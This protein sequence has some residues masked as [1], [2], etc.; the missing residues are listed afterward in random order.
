MKDNFGNELS[1]GDEIYFATSYGMGNGYKL[2]FGVIVGFTN[3]A[4]KVSPKKGYASFD[5]EVKPIF[6][7]SGKVGKVNP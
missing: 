4:I 7:T 5:D 6:I 3:T 1:I 2:A